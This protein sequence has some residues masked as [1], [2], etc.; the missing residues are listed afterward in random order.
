MPIISIPVSLLHL[1]AGSLTV[2]SATTEVGIVESLATF[3]VGADD[4]KSRE[5]SELLVPVIPAVEGG[6]LWVGSS[7]VASIPIL[8]EISPY[9]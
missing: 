5:D 1:V 3:C 7:D 8:F 9:A 6:W 2:P 4:R